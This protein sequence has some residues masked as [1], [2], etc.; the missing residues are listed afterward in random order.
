VI[1]SFHL[2][3]CG[4]QKNWL[5]NCTGV[6][7]AVKGNYVNKRLI[8]FMTL[9]CVVVFAS[10]LWASPLGPHATQNQRTDPDDKYLHKR[11]ASRHSGLPIVGEFYR[12]LES[13]ADEVR[14]RAREKLY[15]SVS[16]RL[17]TPY[18]D[19]GEFADGAQ[20]STAVMIVD[21]L[22][23]PAPGAHQDPPGLPVSGTAV[24]IGTVLS[25]GSFMSNNH[26]AVY[27]DYQVRIDEIVKQAPAGK[28]AVGDEV[29]ASRPGGA[30]HFPSGHTTNFLIIDHGLPAVGSQYILFL[31]KLIPNQPEYEMAFESGYEL[32]NGRVYALDEA[33]EQH[34]DAMSAPAFLELVNR[35]IAESGTKGEKP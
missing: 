32:K 19:P 33:N 1:S 3:R 14:R 18:G 30:I 9:W 31:F 20:E 25:G 28:L 15:E 35:A 24:V 22:R 10:T 6:F 34:Y 29:I 5:S 4:F 13:D 23:I 7:G 16:T 12:Q 2:E 17:P 21:Y 26:T 27:S 11:K 8:N